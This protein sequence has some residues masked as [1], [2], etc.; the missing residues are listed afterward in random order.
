M[1]LKCKLGSVIKHFN[2][3]RT[4]FKYSTNRKLL[5]NMNRQENQT[6]GSLTDITGKSFIVEL[7]KASDFK[8]KD[9][10]TTMW[11]KKL[12]WVVNCQE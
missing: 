8:K 12:G 5:Q 9:K 7:L 3:L 10:K 6:Q 4:I 11:I 1:P 2:L